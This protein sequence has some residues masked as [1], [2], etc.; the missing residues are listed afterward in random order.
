[1]A[2]FLE[3]NDLNA[4]LENLFENAK[5]SLILISPYIKLHQRYISVLKNQINEHDLKI[6]IV[7]GK[8]E[9]DLSKS[10]QED[11]F[12]FFKSF[13]NI[14]IRYEKN[15]HAKYYAN[16]E[17]AI[18]TSMNL[19][20]FSQD[21]NIEA[22]ILLKSSLVG[23]GTG[24]NSLDEEAW[25]YFKRVIQHS[26]LLF[27]KEP[28]YESGF[29]G[30]T[31]KYKSS[32]IHTDKLTDFFEEINNSQP[33]KKQKLENDTKKESRSKL[34]IKSGFCIRTRKQI[35]FNPTRPLCDEAY[36]SWKKFS[37]KDYPEK[38]CHYSGE[39]SNGET[40]FA[41]PI[42]KKNWKKA[43]EDFNL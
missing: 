17:S 22:G 37:N 18:I 27:K 23:F 30:I 31:K 3:G 19:Y 36:L 35:V 2:K 4:G 6:T 15:L 26:E 21:N 24:D 1:M 5:K 42:L 13:P 38:Y 16:D 40:T 41:K 12:N 25:D 7:F 11:D 34:I 28:T 39:P 10:M 14:E 43:K 32:T 29:L 33:A 8:N 20:S 9:D